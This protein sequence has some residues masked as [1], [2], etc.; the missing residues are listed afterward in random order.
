MHSTKPDLMRIGLAFIRLLRLQKYG[1]GQLAKLSTNQWSTSAI[2]SPAKRG[3]Y[4]PTF[5]GMLLQHIRGVVQYPFRYV[6]KSM[7]GTD[8][9]E[10]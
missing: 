10:F 9:H 3:L 6:V 5:C 8:I 4:L 7:K 2:T 1:L